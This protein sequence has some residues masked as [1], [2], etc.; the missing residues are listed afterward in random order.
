MMEQTHS[1]VFLAPQLCGLQPVSQSTTWC[2]YGWGLSQL[3]QL[4]SLWGG[5][6]TPDAGYLTQVGPSPVFWTMTTGLTVMA[7]QETGRPSS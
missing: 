5:G 1:E 3:N 7:G 2:L 6:R 4:G